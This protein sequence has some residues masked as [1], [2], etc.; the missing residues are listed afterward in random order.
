[1][2]AGVASIHQRETVANGNPSFTTETQ[3]HRGTRESGKEGG[4]EESKPGNPTNVLMPGISN[5]SKKFLS[6]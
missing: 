1:M 3:R 2:L 5:Q 6:F 4:K